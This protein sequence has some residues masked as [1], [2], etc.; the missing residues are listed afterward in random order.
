[1][2]ISVMII[3]KQLCMEMWNSEYSMLKKYFNY[4]L[5]IECEC[6]KCIRILI[7]SV[8]RGNIE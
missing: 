5:L 4:F 1:M 7:N 8:Y 6:L 3:N 2:C